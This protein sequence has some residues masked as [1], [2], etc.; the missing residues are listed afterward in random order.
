M[1]NA[2]RTGEMIVADLNKA[3]PQIATLLLAAALFAFLWI[4]LMR[5]FA[6]IMIWLSIL[7]FITLLGAG[8]LRQQRKVHSKRFFQAPLSA[9]IAIT[10]LLQRVRASK[11][12]LHSTT[13]PITQW[14][15][16]SC[17]LV[18]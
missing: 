11:H 14:S 17:G 5:W 10:F 4:V 7:L 6:P 13:E 3:W 16:L 1:L 8:T 2:R 18:S 12:A 9:G 15:S